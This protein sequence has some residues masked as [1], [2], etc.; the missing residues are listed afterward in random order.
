VDVNADG[1]VV[2][3]SASTSPGTPMEAFRWTASGGMVGLGLLPGT[4]SSAASAVS[5]DGSVVF[6]TTSTGATAGSPF[7][8]DAS[9][10]MRDLE[11]VL[12]G[13]FGVNLAGWH[14]SSVNDISTDNRTLVGQG[15]NPNGNYEGFVIVVP[16]PAGAGGV[17]VLL[18]AALVRRR[19]S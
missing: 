11:A 3:G 1:S 7:V 2:V 19:R 14:L 13:N 5:D 8:W 18:S 6:G 9:H 17:A 15:I 10:G 4:T 12:N 16:E